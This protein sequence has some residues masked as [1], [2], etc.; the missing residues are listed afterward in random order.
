MEAPLQAL[1]AAAVSFVLISLLFALLLL[2]FSRPS[3]LRHGD[4]LPLRSPAPA[5]PFPRRNPSFFADRDE[6]ASFDPSLDRISLPELAAATGGFSSDA[7]IG[8]GSFGFVYKAV[9]PSGT[10]VAVKRLSADAAA[11]QGFREF[12]AEMETLGRIRHP[13]LARILGF[14]AS[15]R[16]RLLIYEFLERGS[17][18]S[19]L[20]YPD[21]DP[22]PDRAAPLPWSARARAV[23]GVAAGLAFLH[24]GCEP[25][26][27]HRDIKASNVLLDADFGARIADFGLARLADE[28]HSHV[29]TQAAG[30]MGYMAPEYRDGAVRAT[31]RG[32]V[33]SF[34]MLVFEAATG[35]RPSWPVREDA[36]EGWTE[37]SMARWA[38]TRVEQGRWKDILDPRMAIP[39]EIFDQEDEVKAFLDLA[40]RCTEEC[41]PKRPSMGEAVAILD[42]INSNKL[43]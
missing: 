29:S 8:D 2:F 11:S 28:S 38:R 9:L 33:Y 37:V 40:Y 22:D 12:R 34:G 18:D 43:N 10:A 35:R 25:P 32:D 14:C 39:G 41:A 7:I 6:S 31:P 3:K 19:W 13:N 21:A 30:T 36:A 26:I 23:R 15:G 1:I 42:Q 27:I 24:E 20:H 4:A 16:D 17:L 5:P